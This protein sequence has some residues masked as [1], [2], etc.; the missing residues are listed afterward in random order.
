MV[1]LMV[2]IIS[3]IIIIII[4]IMK[5]HNDD[6]DEHLASVNIETGGFASAR[7]PNQDHTLALNLK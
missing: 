1:I 3:T 4:I 5:N 6:H 2:V 7:C